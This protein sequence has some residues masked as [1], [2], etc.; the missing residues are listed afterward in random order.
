[1][2]FQTTP[3]ETS[4]RFKPFEVKTGMSLAPVIRRH[5]LLDTKKLLDEGLRLQVG[6]LCLKSVNKSNSLFL[7]NKICTHCTWSC[8][9]L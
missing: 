6:T 5:L 4:T 2:L 7:T 9:Q 3:A 1:M 8:Q